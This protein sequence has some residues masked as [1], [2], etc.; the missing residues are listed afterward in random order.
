M[1]YGVVNPSGRLPYTI[2]RRTSD[3]P[4]PDIV[5]CPQPHPQIDYYEGVLVDYR[6]F[7]LNLYQPRFCFGH[8]LS[9]S[10]F[11][12]TDLDIASHHSLRTGI[13]S[14][15]DY[16]ADAPGGDS[17]LFELA[18][19]V[20]L[21]VMNEGPFDGTEVVQLYLS[22]PAEAENPTL[23]LRGFDAVRVRVGESQ[24]INLYMTRKD[25][26]YWD[27]V[28][29]TWVT[30]RKSIFDVYVG[31]SVEDIRLTGHFVTP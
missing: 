28:Q 20:S 3:Y 18:Y 29:Q 8:G 26:S 2:A 17:A 7:R 27:V 9:Y 19:V 13:A 12:Y 23:V 10:T 15:I 21:T 22:M 6:W 4:Q 24:R 1:L 30:P 14:P 31:A 16:V 5:T 11:A 25:V